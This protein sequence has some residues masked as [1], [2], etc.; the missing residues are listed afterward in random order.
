MKRSTKRA[1]KQVLKTLYFNNI[2]VNR[3]YN[4]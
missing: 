4:L 1:L 2:M 3:P